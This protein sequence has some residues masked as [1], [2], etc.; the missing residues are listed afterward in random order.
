MIIRWI[1]EGGV[2]ERCV[3]RCW[4]NVVNSDID[5]VV[6]LKDRSGAVERGIKCIGEGEGIA[7]RLE[8]SKVWQNVAVFVLFSVHTQ[9][10]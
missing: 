3:W 1:V 6:A 2:V 5:E 9:S 8:R 10:Q 4:R 7:R